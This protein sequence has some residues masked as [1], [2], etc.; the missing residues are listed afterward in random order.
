MLLLLTQYGGHI[1][2]DHVLS[3]HAALMNLVADVEF[4]VDSLQSPDGRQAST[5]LQH[6]LNAAVGSHG[7]SLLC[8]PLGEKQKSLAHV[9]EAR[10]NAASV[11]GSV[12]KPITRDYQDHDANAVMIRNQFSTPSGLGSKKKSADEPVKLMTIGNS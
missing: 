9:V 5:V 11:A 4:V 8:S 12:R 6:I 2:L 7:T 1:E 3:V 10:H